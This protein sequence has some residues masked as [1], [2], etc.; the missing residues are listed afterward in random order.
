METEPSHGLL[1]PS[2]FPKLFRPPSLVIAFAGLTYHREIPYPHRIRPTPNAE[3]E[4][5]QAVK[6]EAKQTAK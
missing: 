2:M 3:K 6:P 4:K 1:L 5:P